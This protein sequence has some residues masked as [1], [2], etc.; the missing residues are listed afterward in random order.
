M[1]ITDVHIGMILKTTVDTQIQVMEFPYR[2]RIPA[3]VVGVVKAVK[4]PYVTR[5][6]YFI[7]MEIEVNGILERISVNYK[8]VERVRPYKNLDT[9]NSEI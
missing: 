4:C 3:G 1:E 2:M 8:Q 5:N 7:S 6:G 9:V